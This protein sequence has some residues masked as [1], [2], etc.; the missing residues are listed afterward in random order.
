MHGS[1]SLDGLDAPKNRR[2]GPEGGLVDVQGWLRAPVD[3][4]GHHLERLWNSKHGGSRLGVGLCVANN[5]RRHFLLSN[6]RDDLDSVREELESM[7]AELN[8]AAEA[9]S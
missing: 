5:P 4:D 2:P 3:W 6:V 7:L 1:I 9:R 8:T